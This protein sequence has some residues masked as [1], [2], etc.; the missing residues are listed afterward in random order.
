MRV[1]RTLAGLAAAAALVTTDEDWRSMASATGRPSDPR[2]ALIIGFACLGRDASEGPEK[3]TA[4]FTHRARTRPSRAAIV[5]LDGR[6]AS[7]GRGW[8]GI[9]KHEW[10][11]DAS[12]A[13][14]E[15][16][17]FDDAT[18]PT[19]FLPLQLPANG[20]AIRTIGLRVTDPTD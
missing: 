5:L 2:S 1:R 16:A 13:G 4:A 6:R 11:L 8:C 7:F 19:L 17:E 12:G 18:G 15:A 3:P 14:R 20:A 9:V 10:E